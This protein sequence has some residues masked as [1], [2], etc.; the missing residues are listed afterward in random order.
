MN[1]EYEPELFAIVQESQGYAFIS[2]AEVTDEEALIV[3]RRI[4]CGSLT[5]DFFGC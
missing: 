3:A 2:D 5:R 4:S 1:Q